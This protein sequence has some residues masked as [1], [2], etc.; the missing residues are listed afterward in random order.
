MFKKMKEFL[1]SKRIKEL[2]AERDSYMEVMTEAVEE[3]DKLDIQ[4][5]DITKS[6]REAAR[7]LDQYKGLVFSKDVQIDSKDLQI[8]SLGVALLQSERDFTSIVQEQAEERAMFAATVTEVHNT[9]R[10]TAM[11]LELPVLEE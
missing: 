5:S 3:C 7:Q 10:N 9:I 2:E 8:D 4:V 6:Y 1:K 11:F